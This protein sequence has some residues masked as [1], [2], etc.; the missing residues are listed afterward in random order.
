ME[1]RVTSHGADI[2]PIDALIEFQGDLKTITRANLDKLKRSILKHGFTAPIFVW[3][4]VDNHILDGHQRMKALIE[5]RQEGY[6]IPLLPVVYID[7]D[8]EKH[9]KEKLLYITSQYGDFS[10]DGFSEFVED[11][12]FSFDDIRL[13]DGEFVLEAIEKSQE[14]KDEDTPDVEE[15][16]VSCAGEIYDLGPHRLM[17][18]D[19]TDAA[20][21]AQLMG[22]E[23]ADL[24]LTD[25]PYNVDYTGKTRNALKVSNDSMSDSDFREFLVKA[26]SAAFH[27]MKPGASFYIWHADSEGYN[28][29][30]AAQDCGEKI[31][32]CLIWEKQ[33]MVMGRQDYQWK[34]EPCLY[35]WKSGGS[36]GWYSDRKQTTLL[37]FDRPSKS[38]D[39]P[40]MKPVALFR[41]LIGNSTAPQ[42]VVLD[43]FLGSGTTLIASASLGRKCYGMELDP[44]YCDV[45]RRRWTAWARENG[46]EV[47][48]GA[49][50]PVKSM[51]EAAL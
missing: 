14:E 22:G 25:P 42:G 33:S 37:K 4:G 36:H 28:F 13:T 50:D 12:D 26:Y 18:G 16:A 7:A 39:H 31:R 1:I 40:T 11:M 49:L 20:Q 5:L 15:V 51:N 34:H 44:K 19:S 48:A 17:C 24:W 41:Y 23:H 45:I 8:S 10:S 27:V 9:A 2:L 21:V 35:G 29:R 32:Q 46:C 47:G 30:G 3:K 6:T 43:T 38:E